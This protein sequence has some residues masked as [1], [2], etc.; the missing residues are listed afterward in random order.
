MNRRYRRGLSVALAVS[1]S[2]V[3]VVVGVLLR[4]DPL[5][6]S[7]LPPA[8]AAEQERAPA[9]PVIEAAQVAAWPPP[10]FVEALAPERW[11]RRDTSAGVRW[12]LHWRSDARTAAHL[13]GV[14]CRHPSALSFELTPGEGDRWRIRA[15][16]T[17]PALGAPTRP[18]GNAERATHGGDIEQLLYRAQPRSSPP[19][20]GDQPARD[21]PTIAAGGSGF[22]LIRGESPRR[23][24]VS[25]EI[26]TLE[27]LQ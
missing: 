12:E 1:L 24:Q 6:E 15:S 25:D 23:W 9:P 17:E 4:S 14:L 19:P 8:P 18:A 21:L 13:L 7:P 11:V 22:V 20:A 2:A 10:P 27:P 16:L 5:R 26:L 3:S